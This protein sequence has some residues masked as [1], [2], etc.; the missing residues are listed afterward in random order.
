MRIRSAV[1]VAAL[2]A[3]VGVAATGFPRRLGLTASQAAVSLPGDLLVPGADVVA[4]RGIEVPASAARLACRTQGSSKI[5]NKLIAI[6]EARDRICRAAPRKLAD[7]PD[8]KI[9]RAIP[10]KTE[11]PLQTQP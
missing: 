10:G 3:A 4:D 11:P 1:V 5:L 9:R 2:A 6:E 8:E 7:R